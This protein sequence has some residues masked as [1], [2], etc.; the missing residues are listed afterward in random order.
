MAHDEHPGR[1]PPLSRAPSY[2]QFAPRRAIASFEN[3]VVLANYEERLRGARMIVWRDRGEKPVELDDLWE[4]LEHASRGAARAGGVGFAIRAGVNL[5]LLLT[6]IKRIPKSQRLAVIQHALFGEDCF[7]FAGMLGS[8]VGLYK[9]ILNALPIL[10]PKPL[11]YDADDTPNFRASLRASAPKNLSAPDDPFVEGSSTDDANMLTVPRASRQA[12]LSTNAQAHQQWVR[13]KTRR[14]YSILA[15]AIAGAVAVGFEKEG[16]RTT[17]AQQL[18]VRGLQGS[19][20]TF[21]ARSGYSLPH[22]DVLLFSLCCG[23][24]LYSFL[25]RPDT[26]P[27]AYVNWMSHACKVHPSA[28]SVNRDLVTEGHFKIPDLD[29][30]IN[31]K[32]IAPGNLTELLERKRLAQLPTPDFGTLVGPCATIHPRIESCTYVQLERFFVVVRWMLPI[33]GALTV[34]PMLLFKRKAVMREPVR[35]LVK[36]LAGTVRSSSFL[37]VFVVL[38]QS[39]NCGKYNLYNLLTSFRS[40]PTPSLLSTLA[41]FI[42]QKLV[43]VLIQK[44]SFWLGGALSG[45]SLFVEEAHRREE[46]AMY[47]LPRGLEG[48][49]G[50]LRDRGL[51][52]GMGSAGDVLLTSIGMGMV[53]SIYQNDPQHLS[54]LVRRILYQFVG[55]N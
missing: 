24:I 45:L 23:Q 4:C 3:L 55:P 52:R 30:I 42:P 20:N 15:G 51:V 29:Y 28:V 13:K 2:L 32:D 49:W 31:R 25:I 5:I 38:F 47:V 6:R 37:G 41:R 12:R 54:G 34:I 35:M 14:W 19:Y 44:P 40:S 18:F 1:P 46:L 10:L 9:L 8:F 43:D 36:A 22:G 33:Y 48:A 26:L 16:R 53:M 27:P 21:S 39:F 7:R 50:V 11:P 17:I